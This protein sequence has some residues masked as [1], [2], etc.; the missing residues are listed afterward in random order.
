MAL[1]SPRTSAH[2]IPVPGAAAAPVVN[3]KRRGRLPGGVRRLDAI[4]SIRFERRMAL[5]PKVADLPFVADV[6]VPGTQR[7]KRRCFWHV[8][9]GSDYSAACETGTSYARAYLAYIAAGGES[10]ILTSVVTDMMKAPQDDAA[11]GYHAGFWAEIGRAA[12][13]A[14]AA[15]KER[16]HV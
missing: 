14:M 1:V 2:V 5:L 12:T 8:A 6:L 7:T 10:T 4:H 15:A 13:F 11:R 3:P 9:P 16:A